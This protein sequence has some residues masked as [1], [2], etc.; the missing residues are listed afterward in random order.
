MNLYL[1]ECV[2]KRGKFWTEAQEVYVVA[3]DPGDAAQL[4]LDRLD[5]VDF[6]RRIEL[7]AGELILDPEL[8][9]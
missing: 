9:A 8:G 7:M 6:V 1:V 3:L 5:G 2:T 4:A